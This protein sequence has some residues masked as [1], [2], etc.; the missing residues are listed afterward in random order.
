MRICTPTAFAAL[1][2]V[3]CA[4]DRDGGPISDL[5]AGRVPTDTT[6]MTNDTGLTDP[7]TVDPVVVDPAAV[8]PTV[9]AGVTDLDASTTDASTEDAS[10]DVDGSVTDD[11]G[12]KQHDG[13]DDPDGGTH[14]ED[15]ASKPMDPPVEPKPV[16]PTPVVCPVMAN[17][18]W[19][20]AFTEI[21]NEC[22]IALPEVAF[23]PTVAV[24]DAETVCGN[25]EAI[26]TYDWAQ[27]PTTCEITR[28][29]HCTYPDGT[30][31]DITYRFTYNVTVDVI[32]GTR[33]EIWN[34]TDPCAA[35][36]SLSATRQ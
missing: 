10:T 24:G 1:L 17:G 27:N 7:A 19:T 15:D 34:D 5:P 21:T 32:T 2:L 25:A 35:S 4:S 33:D 30:V 18:Y 36:F 8:D 31:H 22:G 12:G 20:I 9:D 3:A 16:E 23:D 29:E 11:D 28:T 6:G 13:K 14:H 26:H